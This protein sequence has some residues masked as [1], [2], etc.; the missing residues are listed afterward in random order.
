[1]R[2]S[3]LEEEIEGIVQFLVTNV[4]YLSTSDLFEK[5]KL[6]KLEGKNESSVFDIIT[7]KYLQGKKTKEEMI[8]YIVRKSFRFMKDK[9]G[10]KEMTS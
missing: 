4:G 3:Q 2:R 9:M 6:S 1:M 5:K 10:F 8:K 7:Q